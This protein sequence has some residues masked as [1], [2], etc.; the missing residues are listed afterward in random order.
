MDH[1]EYRLRLEDYRVFYDVEAETVVVLAVVPKEDAE[2]WLDQY[3]V[4]SQ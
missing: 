4:K 3:G 2:S 1:P